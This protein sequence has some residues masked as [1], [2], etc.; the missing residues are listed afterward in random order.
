MGI[1][2]YSYE[3]MMLLRVLE[4]N[5][6]LP[7]YWSELILLAEQLLTHDEREELHDMIFDVEKMVLEIEVI[8]RELTDGRLVWVE[9]I[10]GE[11]SLYDIE[12]ALESNPDFY[13]YFQ[14]EDGRM[15]TKFDIERE[16]NR[17]KAW[18]FEKVRERAENRRFTRFR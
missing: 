8:P 14:R 9:R 5:S 12:M 18:L 2:R 1:Q 7:H 11:L 10:R 13:A 16:L 4:L 17:I 6:L 15:I 3:E